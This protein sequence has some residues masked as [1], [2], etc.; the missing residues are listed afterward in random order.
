MS[1]PILHWQHSTLLLFQF[2][3]VT[4]FITGVPVFIK[5]NSA[6]M[7]SLVAKF[8]TIIIFSNVIIIQYNFSAKTIR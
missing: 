2:H 7:A 4:F 6:L 1:Y 3:A 5:T 8:T